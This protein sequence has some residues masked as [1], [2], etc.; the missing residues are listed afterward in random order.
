LVTSIIIVLI[1]QLNCHTKSEPDD[2]ARGWVTESKL[3]DYFDTWDIEYEDYEALESYSQQLDS[4][5]ESYTVKIFL[6]TWCPDSE[7]EIPRFMK[8]IRSLNNT[9][10]D[11]SFFGLDRTDA[12]K[13][14]MREK[15]DITYVPTFIIYKGEKEIG[16]IIET[17]EFSLEEDLFSICSNSQ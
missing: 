14:G 17:P 10:F 2:M 12:D 13:S 7:R 4:L 6:G 1:I 5:N 11:V 15:Y 8:V 3:I 16:R 9:S